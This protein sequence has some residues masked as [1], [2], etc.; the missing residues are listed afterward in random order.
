[1]K[2]IKLILI[3]TLIAFVSIA[4]AQKSFVASD[5]IQGKT[6]TK[7]AKEW[8]LKAFQQTKEVYTKGMSQE[9]FI[10]AIKKSFPTLATESF[11]E[12]FVP[13]YEYIYTFHARGLTDAQVTNT[14][15]GRETTALINGL[16]NFNSNNSG[17]IPEV[18]KWNWIRILDIVAE[19]LEVIIGI[20]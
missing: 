17:I 19:I 9:A 5:V 2:S 8:D 6:I 1:M 18:D 12:V 4:Q 13:Y 14:I 10:T 15:T 16:S 7:W 20:L 3:A 11:K